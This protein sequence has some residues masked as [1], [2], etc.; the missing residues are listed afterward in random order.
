MR[1]SS[2]GDASHGLR[3]T[4]DGC[5]TTLLAAPLSTQYSGRQARR[6]A[7]P[8]GIRGTKARPRHYPS[9]LLAPRPAAKWAWLS[10]PPSRRA[11]ARSIASGRA[12]EVH[13][14]SFGLGSTD[15]FAP[16]SSAGRR[17]WL[18]ATQAPAPARGLRIDS[19]K[20]TRRESSQPDL[21]D[22]RPK[23]WPQKYNT[24]TED[25]TC[26]KPVWMAGFMT[27]SLHPIRFCLGSLEGKRV[28]LSAPLARPP[29]R[30]HGPP[31]T[32]DREHADVKAGTMIRMSLDRIVH[33]S[34]RSRS[35]FPVAA[36]ALSR[37]ARE[38]ASPGPVGNGK[39]DSTTR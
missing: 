22:I 15:A 12:A 18:G 10:S 1:H 24:S 31:G 8:S 5:A 11:G 32:R 20:R 2:D 28:P 26:E 13:T 35:G 34:R 33:F 36:H 19:S 16:R 39:N 7:C 6:D 17:A 4:R 21:R 23:F 30:N 3:P 29:R 38:P 14:G 27:I 25:P 9:G 37:A